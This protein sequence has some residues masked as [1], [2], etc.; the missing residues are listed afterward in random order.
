MD[1]LYHKLS[2]KEKEEIRKQVDSILNS[3][4]AKLSKLS[5]LDKKDEKESF[6]EREKDE[7]TE[8]G[9]KDGSFSREIMFKN[10]P[11]KNKDFIIAE[12]KKW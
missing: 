1:F 5:K 4:S 8:G 11:E 9:E 2:E 7:R 10:A 12:K 3:F 6:I